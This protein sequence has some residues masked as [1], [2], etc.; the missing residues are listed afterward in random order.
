MTKWARLLDVEPFL[1]TA[2]MEE[3]AAWSDHSTVHVLAGT[4]RNMEHRRVYR[5][6]FNMLWILIFFLFIIIFIFNIFNINC[7]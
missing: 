1:Q 2:S 3:M 7:I 5:V 4:S 6:P